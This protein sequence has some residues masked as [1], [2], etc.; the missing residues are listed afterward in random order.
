MQ[1][2]LGTTQNAPIVKVGHTTSGVFGSEPMAK[3]K[4]RGE[5]PTEQTFGGSSK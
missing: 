2:N 5:K 4:G 3:V 1:Q